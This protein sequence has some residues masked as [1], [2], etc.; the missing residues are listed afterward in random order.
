ML[1]KTILTTLLASSLFSLSAFAELPASGTLQSAVIA[2]FGEPR[3]K[4]LPIGQPPITRWMYDNFTVV[5][6]Y[7]HVVTAFS[8]I[9]K[10]ENRPLSTI[11]ERPDYVSLIDQSRNKPEYVESTAAVRNDAPPAIQEEQVE[12][13]NEAART[14][15]GLEMAV[16]S[17]A[18]Q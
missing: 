6:E 11:P 7:D 18:M 14:V 16:P 12:Q 17:R 10:V 15:T 13:A 1:N 3:D 8:R 9:P 2:E 5:F 4:T